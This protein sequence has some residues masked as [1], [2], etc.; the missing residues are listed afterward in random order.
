MNVIFLG[1][2]GSGKSTQAK[3]LS[4]RLKLPL[5][6][7]GQLFRDRTKV[8]DGLGRKIKKSLD[9]GILV[10]DEIAVKTLRDELAKEIYNSGFI[11][12]GYPRNSN[13]LRGLNTRI[14]K[15]FYIKVSD[16]EAVKRL[17]LRKREDDTEELLKKRLDIYHEKTEPLLDQF[18][19]KGIL[20]EING[21]QSIEEVDRD[22][23][24][25]YSHGL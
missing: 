24:K 18:R 3:M 15:V 10:E 17:L 20:S 22:V 1:P 4:D 13:Q 7:M 16:Q 19:Q 11:L 5:I 25:V 9:A 23:M 2:Q 6:E 12:D 14:D 8:D 21:E